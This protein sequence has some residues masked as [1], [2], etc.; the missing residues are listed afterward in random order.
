LALLLF[1]FTPP[2]ASAEAVLY[3]SPERGSYTVGQTFD[4]K[5]YA[6]T[7]GALVNAA[8]AEISFNADAL[9]VQ[10]ISTDESILQSWTSK[11]E[12]SNSE[13]T[14]HFAGWTKKN[15][16]GVS[17]LLVTVTFK[18]LRTS[19]GSARLAAGAILAADG[20]ESN[21]ITG[22]R[23]GVFTIAPEEIRESPSSAELA[24]AS[25]SNAIKAKVPPPVFEEYPDAV[26]E[27]DRIVIRGYAEANSHVNIWLARGSEQE[28]RTEILTA[29]DGSFTYVS[30]EKT[31]PGV[32]HLRG[33]VETEDGRE[34]AQTESIDITVAPS[35]VAATAITS[36][37][38]LFEVLPFFALLVIGGLGAA[39]LYHRHQLAKMH[40]GTHSM[41][42]QQD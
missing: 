29:A 41:F 35:G 23:S 42:D 6:D 14:I 34:S 24:Q 38:L 19:V 25:S 13:G 9:E 4:M 21:I 28:K 2:V 16:S 7:G 5:V 40:Y 3:I 31:V 10:S 18:A 30:D 15:Y 22:M 26:S 27:G 1:V 11:P 37:S 20:Q 8:E 32:Y 33:T 39:Y 17:G 36:V 12:F